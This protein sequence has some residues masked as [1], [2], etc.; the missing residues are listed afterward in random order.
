MRHA[1]QENNTTNLYAHLDHHHK[2]AY[3]KMSHYKQTT[4][5]LNES[6]LATITTGTIK[7]TLPLRSSKCHKKNLVNAIGQFIAKNLQPIISGRW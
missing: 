4:A 3:V 5:E 2:E 6:A 7:K 1:V